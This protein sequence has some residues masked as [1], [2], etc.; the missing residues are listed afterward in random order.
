MPQALKCRWGTVSEDRA[1][2][3]REG[4]RGG[5]EAGDNNSDV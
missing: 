4:G 5:R 3:G 1:E 2:A